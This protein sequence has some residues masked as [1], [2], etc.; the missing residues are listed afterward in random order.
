MFATR[1]H[2]VWFD[3]VDRMRCNLLYLCLAI[4]VAV[5]TEGGVWVSAARGGDDDQAL[6]DL[7][8]PDFSETEMVSVASGSPKP[9]LQVPE[10]VV[11]IDREEIEAMHAHTLIEV[12]E[13]QAGVVPSYFGQDFGSASRFY[14]Q[15]TQ[16][17]HTLVLMDG[18]RINNA[19][20]GEA[21]TNFIPLQIVQRIELI[22]GP[23]SSVWGSS[24]GGVVNVITKDTGNSPRPAGLMTATYGEAAS[25]EFAGE[26]AGKNGRAGYYLH[27]ST[28]ASDGLRNDRLFDRD[29]VYGKMRL[30]LSQRSSLTVAAGYADPRLSSG[31]F[32]SLDFTESVRNRNLW[33]AIYF[34]AP[35]SD[36][37]GFHLEGQRFAMDHF[38]EDIKIG[39]TTYAGAAGDFLQSF[40]Y[41]EATTSLAGRFFWDGEQVDATVGAETS[42]SRLDYTYRYDY[43]PANPWVGVEVAPT[44]HDERRA[45]YANATAQF[46]ALAVTPGCRYDYHS[47][48]GEFI[49]PSLGATYR[50]SPDTL[51]RGSVARGFSAPYLA[52]ISGGNI[53]KPVN[54]NLEPE[55]VH[56]IQVGVETNRFRGFHLKGAVFHHR[57]DDVW[58]K[59]APT[60]NQ[61]ITE[62]EG[63]ELE[64][65][66]LPWRHFFFTFTGT[67]VE[68]DSETINE[69]TLYGANFIFDYNDNRSLKAQLAGRYFSYNDRDL[70][71][72][73]GNDRSA[74]LDCLWDASVTKTFFRQGSSVD[75]F[76]KVHNLFD[77]GFYWDMEYANPGRWFEGGATLR[78]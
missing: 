5:F 53:F 59:G 20:G 67:Y 3:I 44:A 64:F 71:D 23:A 42:R 74:D 25:R 76:F 1:F 49:S 8:F 13:R 36:R 69:G 68:E 7:Y 39:A 50:L 26:L 41:N 15:G 10:N 61:G 73:A 2:L 21:L 54:P 27:G 40:S 34:D 45:I 14:L 47:I 78:F 55:K 9:L 12:L 18:V 31:D 52:T 33:G 70:V 35:L 43:L 28:M 72:G 63:M 6:M 24:L 37:L 11:I 16:H 17:Y 60:V 4:F 30:E 66:T 19:S 62:Y 51:L 77:G 75:L 57:I 38:R 46:G 58:G 32:F 22:K 65:R 56:S 29:S 48:T